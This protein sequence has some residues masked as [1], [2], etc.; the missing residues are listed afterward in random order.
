MGL[1][2]VG[3]DLATKQQQLITLRIL[4]LCYSGMEKAHPNLRGL[5]TLWCLSGWSLRLN[6]MSMSGGGSGGVRKSDPKDCLKKKSQIV[7]GSR[8][9]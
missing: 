1:Q 9:T 2:R 4:P 8:E 5:L 6:D 3:H 7:D